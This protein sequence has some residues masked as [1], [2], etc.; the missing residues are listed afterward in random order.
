M[1]RKELF[2][3][4]IYPIATISGSIIGAGFFALPYITLKVGIWIMLLYFLILGFLVILINLI[5]GEIAI[6]TPDFK[7]LPGFVGFH[8]GK[9][10]GRLSSVLNIAGSFGVLLVYLII[11]SDFLFNVFSSVFG[12]S[13]ILYIF[14]YFALASLIIYFGIRIVSRVELGVICFLLLVLISI[15]IKDFSQIKIYNFFIKN[16]NFGI[17]DLFLPYGTIIF[18]LWGTGMIPEMEEMLGKNKRLIKKI[19][20]IATLVPI[21]IY[22]FFILLVLGITG[23]AT[24]QSALLGLKSFLGNGLV[25]LGILIGVATTFVGFITMGL[26]LKKTLIYDLKVKNFHAWIVTCFTPLILFLIGLNSFIGLISFIGGV[27]LSVEGIFILLMYKKIGGKKLL[28]YPLSLIFI[29][30]I[31]YE[32]VYFIF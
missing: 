28:I 19:I 17:K 9:W 12:G 21:I 11:G 5:Y 8:L 24:T 26:T 1:E 29:F 10:P 20:I 27:L 32:L 25:S 16:P 2:R 23:S 13:K 31:I 3:N 4:Y 18:S 30:G 14:I 15:F 6:K 7:R 22:L